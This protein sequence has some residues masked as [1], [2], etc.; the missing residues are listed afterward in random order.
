M[1]RRRG[2][3][4]ETIG[5]TQDARQTA[6]SGLTLV[7]C[8]VSLF[9]VALLAALVGPPML[10]V[11]AAQI[12]AQRVQQAQRLA[13]AEVDRVRS[14][15][16]Q[17]DGRSN[18]GLS[19]LDL[20]PVTTATP[21]AQ[22]PPPQAIAAL[23]SDYGHCQTNGSPTQAG[24][25]IG[26]DLD[27]DAN[28]DAEFLLQAFRTDSGEGGAQATFELMVRVYAFNGNFEGLETEMASVGIGQ[29]AARRPLA[30]TTTTLT[31]GGTP[32]A[33]LCYHRQPCGGT[34]R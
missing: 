9:T 6:E 5:R 29:T 34:G 27:G 22:Q 13:Q 4:R 3:R 1:D 17:A 24:E 20:P 2:V 8:L 11:S 14:Q 32:G 33:L 26:I 16:G 31:L 7:E 28:C 19:N 12:Q 21:L 30:V 23:R 10:W 15:M 25:A 18:L